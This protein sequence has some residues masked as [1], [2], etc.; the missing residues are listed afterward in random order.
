MRLSELIDQ[1]QAALG[2]YG[3]MQVLTKDEDNMNLQHA[4]VGVMT[5]QTVKTGRGWV[6]QEILPIAFIID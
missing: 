6:N 3:D 2:K 4:V 5:N 1:A